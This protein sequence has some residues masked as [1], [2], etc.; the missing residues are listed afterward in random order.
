MEPDVS[1]GIGKEV[2]G[3]VD[4]TDYSYKFSRVK[5]PF[6]MDHSPQDIESSESR[7]GGMLESVPKKDLIEAHHCAAV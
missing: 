2:K 6:L 5:S 4:H 3:I 7:R 1:F